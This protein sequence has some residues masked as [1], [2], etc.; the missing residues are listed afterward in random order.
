MK[1]PKILFP[2]SLLL[3]SFCLS[4]APLSAQQMGGSEAQQQKV[5]FQQQSMQTAVDFVDALNR[6]DLT[7]LS[8]YIDLNT[9]GTGI[10]TRVLSKQQDIND[11]VSGFTQPQNQTKMVQNM[12]SSVFQDNFHA[13]F[14][15]MLN[16]GGV[17]RPLIRISYQDGGLEYLILYL[18]EQQKIVDTYMATSGKLMTD[19]LT[20]ATS[21]MINTDDSF[22]GRV[23]GSKKIDK[24]IL[25]S[26]NQI[27]SLRRSGNFEQAFQVLK[28]LPESLQKERVIIDLGVVLAQSISDE[29]YMK[30][31]T[32]L[33]DNFANDPSTQF[34]LIDY[35]V[36]KEDF[37][38]VISSIYNVIERFGPDGHLYEL[39][40][41]VHHTMGKIDLSINASKK[42]INA[43]PDYEGNYWMLNYLYLESRDF[44]AVAANL[45]Q[46]EQ[47]LGY[48]FSRESLA[49]EEMFKEFIQ[50]DEFDQWL[51]NKS[52]GA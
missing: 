17:E 52:D 49:Q 29:E 34:L 14:M 7:K 5:S 25:E 8:Q 19:A 40:A 2:V 24:D 37:Q 35:Y 20:Q 10:A 4:T 26:F 28:S 16:E 50:S 31:L 23:L 18:S 15:R 41:N 33:A 12:F 9:I 21:L 48:E 22:L 39:A 3:A 42:G 44:A 13:Q 27:G 45:S 32:L 38:K 36:V 43:E 30:Q 46:I 6:Q 47:K 11:F 1:Y 51:K